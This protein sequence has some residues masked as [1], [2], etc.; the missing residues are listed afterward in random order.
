MQLLQLQLA[1]IEKLKNL[2]YETYRKVMY[3]LMARCRGIYDKQLSPEMRSLL[4]ATATAVRNDDKETGPLYRQ[5]QNTIS[6]DTP[7]IDGGALNLLQLAWLLTG[8]TA[9]EY[10]QYEAAEMAEAPISNHLDVHAF[11]NLDSADWPGHH[12]SDLL[13]VLQDIVALNEDQLRRLARSS[14]DEAGRIIF[15]QPRQCQEWPGRPGSGWC[16]FSL[17]QPVLRTRQH[18]LQ[19]R[20]PPVDEAVGLWRRSGYRRRCGVV[21]VYGPGT[22]TNV[23]QLGQQ[24]AAVIGADAEPGQERGERQHDG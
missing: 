8:E 19:A 4:T 1:V 16:S 2:P 6:N 9:G 21:S 12:G 13:Q 20:G 14:F 3:A 15:D 11:N 24:I 7:G 23:L 10:P 5:L 17:W 18:R 22:P